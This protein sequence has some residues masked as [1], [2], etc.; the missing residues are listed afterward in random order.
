[1]P[2]RSALAAFGPGGITSENQFRTILRNLHAQ[3]LISS[4]VENELLNFPWNE[5]RSAVQD[6][7]SP[8]T[9]RYNDL[10]LEE[11][12]AVIDASIN[13]S[14]PVRG[15]QPSSLV[16]F[17]V[18]PAS[19]HR[20][21]GPSGRNLR[22]TPVPRLRTVMVQIGYSRVVG[23]GPAALVDVSFP[24]PQ[25]PQQR[26]YPGVEFPGEGIFIMLDD[27]NG[28]HFPML[29]NASE[30][31]FR[32][33][34]NPDGYPQQ[35]FRTP[36]HDELHPVF[37]WWHTLAHLLVRAISIYAGYSSASIRERIYLQVD[38]EN[39]RI[40]GGIILYATQPGSEGTMGGL[41]ALVPH[42]DHIMNVALDMLRTCSNDPL[43]IENHFRSSGYNGPACYGCLLVSETSC[44]HKNLWLDREVLLNNLP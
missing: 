19:V 3:N 2:V 24:D 34:R 27:N 12:S 28:W 16:L 43:C 35:I 20:F 10:L 32:A 4:A 21:P 42:F 36:L 30:K 26:W 25:N 40:K 18:V 37:V 15:P 11:F 13:G 29:G 23:N 33:F 9:A 17:E 1:M 31:W 39:N 6:I 7:L 14:P 8:I 44:E 38:T 5:I 22:I 41:I